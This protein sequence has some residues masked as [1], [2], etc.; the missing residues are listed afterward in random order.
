MYLVGVSRLQLKYLMSQC[1]AI[2]LIALS[3]FVFVAPVH[4]SS[5]F[6]R[7]SVYGVSFI[8]LVARFFGILAW[9]LASFQGFTWL[10]RSFTLS[11]SF[12]I[13]RLEV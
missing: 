6:G 5:P 1:G 2:W 13:S 3:S 12:S 9:S 8:H 7:P 10:A 11:H 4:H